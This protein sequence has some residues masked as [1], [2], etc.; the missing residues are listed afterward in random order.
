MNIFPIL[1]Q[2]RSSLLFSCGR[3]AFIL[4]KFASRVQAY[5]KAYI[6]K[7]L[8]ICSIGVTFNPNNYVNNL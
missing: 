4:H 7:E 5:A 3:I 2:R 8:I 1:K 6:L